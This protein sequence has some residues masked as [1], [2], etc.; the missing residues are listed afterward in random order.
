[1]PVLR[2]PITRSPDCVAKGHSEYNKELIGLCCYFDRDTFNRIR[3]ESKERKLSATE[4]V[5]QYVDIGMVTID[6]EKKCGG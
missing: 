6:E 4:I 2:S 3:T 5:R 1:M